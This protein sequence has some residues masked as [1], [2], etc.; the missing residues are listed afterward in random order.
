MK[1]HAWMGVLWLGCF[2][3]VTT[4]SAQVVRKSETPSVILQELDLESFF[5]DFNTANTFYRKQTRAESARN[6]FKDLNLEFVQLSS[7]R[8]DDAIG[9]TYDYDRTFGVQN[10]AGPA[11]WTS[12]FNLRSVGTLSFDSA[13]KPR[14]FLDTRVTWRMAYDAGGLCDAAT[15]VEAYT[16]GLN[17]Y[18]DSQGGICV[19]APPGTPAANMEL[20]EILVDFDDPAT[21][22]AS[23]AWHQAVAIASEMLSDQTHFDFGLDLGVENSQDF[24]QRQYRL[25]LASTLE[26]KTWDQDSYL[27]WLNVVDYPASVLRY[28]T[29]YDEE[30]GPSG[31]TF[32][33]VTVDVSQIV[34]DEN[35]ARRTA[36]DDDNFLRAH[37]EASYRSALG[38]IGTKLYHLDASYQYYLDVDP[39]SSI[40]SADLDQYDYLKAEISTDQGLFFAIDVGQL[41]FEVRDTTVVSLGYRVAAR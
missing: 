8:G 2:G 38:E 26:Y 20:L 3:L 22:E 31:T 18:R 4:A 39:S 34:V 13:V 14:D 5:C 24:A 35:R 41:P 15:M 36:G 10:P 30:W 27:P 9:L 29:G 32:P 40:Q 37:L 19:E 33:I 7:S 25:G 6:I 28:L 17:R 1:A 16:R 23:A 12:F 11:G 21:L